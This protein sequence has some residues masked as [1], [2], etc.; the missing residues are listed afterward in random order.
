MLRLPDEFLTSAI[1]GIPHSQMTVD[2]LQLDHGALKA[3]QVLYAKYMQKMSAEP[4]CPLCHKD[5]STVELDDLNAEMHDELRRL[6]DKLATA[7]RA[8]HA[9]RHK[10]ETLLSL[11][12]QNERIDVLSST[13]IPRLKSGLGA[14]ETRLAAVTA[15][16]ENLEM[17][18]AE[19]AADLELAQSLT[20]DMT[21][22]DEAV[23]DAQTLA[24]QVQDM[25][26]GLPERSS[27]LTLEEAQIQRDQLQRNVRTARI[28]LE[29]AQKALRDGAERLNTLRERR[30]QLKASE[31]AMQEG[32]QALGELRKRVVQLETDIAGRILEAADRE[33]ILGP[34]RLEFDEATNA[35]RETRERNRGTLAADGERLADWQRVE[36]EVLRCGGELRR[37]AELRLERELGEYWVGFSG[38]H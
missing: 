3:S 14:T 37:L 13:E 31:I 21:L 1:R 22:L 34:L 2:K 5:M 35:K 16:E 23:R 6:P 12:S 20:G 4:C 18:L 32:V 19:P 9:D 10:Y 27:A 30:N 7:E 29:R 28:D 25:Q 36:R 38:S 8:L 11:A 33:A 15:D 17:T 26:R 24:S